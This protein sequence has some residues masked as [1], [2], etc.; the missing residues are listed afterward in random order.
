MFI[1]ASPHTAR[2]HV[3]V[4]QPCMSLARTLC[5]G[6]SLAQ[7]NTGQQRKGVAVAAVVVAAVVVVSV[8]VVVVVV[9]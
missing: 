4:A 2:T 1:A 6:H 5:A 7:S 8:V 3:Q 9:G